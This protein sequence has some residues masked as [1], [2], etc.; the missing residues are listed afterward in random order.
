ML[1]I[2]HFHRNRFLFFYVFICFHCSAK[3]ELL[4]YLRTE[5]DPLSL[6]FHTNYDNVFHSLE[7]KISRKVSLD[8]SWSS[9]LCNHWSIWI[10]L[11]LIFRVKLQLNGGLTKFHSMIDCKGYQWFLYLYRLTLA[12]SDFLRIKKFYCYVVLMVL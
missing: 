12:V 2:K 11:I 4:C 10:I 7:Q 3:L 1:L 5:F 9:N 8:N 6:I